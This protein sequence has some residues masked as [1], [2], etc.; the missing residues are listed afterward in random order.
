[1]PRRRSG[2]RWRRYAY[3]C[4]A[5]AV[6]VSVACLRAAPLHWRA[7]LFFAVLFVIGQQLRLRVRPSDGVSLSANAI[8]AALSYPLL[9]WA[10]ALPALAS[11]VQVRS[12]IPR[13]ARLFNAATC[14]LSVFAG[15]VVYM[16]TGGP[17]GRL[18]TTGSVPLALASLLLAM[19]AFTLT[20]VSL[21]AGVMYLDARSHTPPTET[22][23]RG[24][25]SATLLQW[26]FGFVGYMVAQLWLGHAGP[27]AFLL[28]LLPVAV[29]QVAIVRGEAEQRVHEATLLALAQALETKDPYTRGHGERVAESSRMLASELGWDR[30]RVQMIGFAGLLHDVG[31]IAV[32]TG[33]IR[34]EG[35]L[36]RLEYEAVQLHPLRGV[37]V[38]RSI[39]FLHDALAGIRHHHERYD[40]TG[41]PAGLTGEE[42]PLF[43]R[44]LA[45]ADAYDA[46]TTARTYRRP[47][48]HEEALQQLRAGRGE[49]FD[50]EQVDA[51][52]SLLGHGQWRPPTSAEPADLPRREQPNESAQESDR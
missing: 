46:M 23:R 1:M 6:A 37:E 45:I 31:K 22:L 7:Q 34:K 21:L 51:F 24:L 2:K 39:E 20:N 15:G 4:I 13:M 32:P 5:A 35:P 3:L 40:G 52:M 14:A 49:Q 44:V 41:Y 27:I 16:A 29:G 28:M 42:I 36:S 12:R 30:D 17:V 50:P 10:A 19:A 8:V 47:R 25:T 43:A 38:V 9:G 18:I 33:I 48:T 26:V 11:A